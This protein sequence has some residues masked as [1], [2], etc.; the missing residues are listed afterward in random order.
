VIGARGTLI[1]RV[2]PRKALTYILV[3]GGIVSSIAADAG[4]LV[5]VPLGATAF[6]SVGRHPLAGLAA[7]FAGVAAVFTVNIL[8]KPLDGILT[9]ITNDA[10]HLLNPSVSINLM[11]G[12]VSAG[13]TKSALVKLARLRNTGHLIALGRGGTGPNRGESRSAGNPLIW[14]DNNILAAL[15]D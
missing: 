5:L 6:W 7:S 15:Q 12:T 3:L 2:V 9:G 10:I 11:V 8:V 14:P 1:M 4:Y 13:A